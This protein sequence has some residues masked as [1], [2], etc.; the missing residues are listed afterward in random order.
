MP[1]DREQIAHELRMLGDLYRDADPALAA[2]GVA[3]YLE[4]V[5]G[6]VLSDEQLGADLLDPEVALRLVASAVSD[7]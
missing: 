4:D 1:A 2:L 6:V 7:S 5:S 3:V